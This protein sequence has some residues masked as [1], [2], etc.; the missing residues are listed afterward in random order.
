[1]QNGPRASNLLPRNDSV[2]PTILGRVEIDD[3]CNFCQLGGMEE[4]MIWFVI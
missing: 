1:M 2:G 3:E 4:L